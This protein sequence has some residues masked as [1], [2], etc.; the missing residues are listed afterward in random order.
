MTRAIF[1]GFASHEFVAALFV[2]FTV[3]HDGLL[4]GA[5]PLKSALI[6]AVS[7]AC[8][9]HGLRQGLPFG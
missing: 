6:L 8:M 2:C 5:I 4:P 3:P 1:H 7:L 9:L